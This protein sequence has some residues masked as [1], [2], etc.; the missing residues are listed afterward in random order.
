MIEPFEF[1]SMAE[2]LVRRGFSEEDAVR[3][4]YQVA[5][6]HEIDDQGNT[7]VRDRGAIVALIPRSELEGQPGGAGAA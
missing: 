7:V 5:D 6:I 4:A 2:A 3:L 1:Q